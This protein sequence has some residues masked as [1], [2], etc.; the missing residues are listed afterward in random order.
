M[1]LR[2]IILSGIIFLSGNN[3]VSQVLPKD[4]D[5]L[6]YRL[7]GFQVPENKNATAYQLEVYEFLAQDDGNVEKLVLKKTY[8]RNRII[9]TVPQFGKSYKWQV[10]YLKNSQVIGSSGFHYFS[11]GYSETVDTSKYR[12]KVLENKVKDPDIY[13]VL[14]FISVIY[15]LDGN[16]LWYLPNIPVVADKNIQ[17][18]DLKPTADGTFTAVSGQGAHEFDYN[19]KILWTAAN[20]GTVSGAQNESYHHEFTKLSNGHFMVCG[21]EPLLKKVPGFVDTAMLNTARV[22]WH[23]DEECYYVNLK[24]ETLIEYDSNGRVV[25]YWK[26]S[27]HCSDKDFFRQGANKMTKI[28]TDMH[29]NAFEFDEKEKVI[30]ISFKNTNQ[31]VKIEYPS[32]KIIE[33]YGINSDKKQDNPDTLFYGQ[34]CIRK[35]KDGRLYLFNNNSRVLN[36]NRDEDHGENTS[37]SYITML[38]ENPE[39]RSGIEK[40]WEFPC[41]IDTF[42][43]WAGGAGG[44][45]TMLDNGDILASMGAASRVFIVTPDK[46]VLWNGIPQVSDPGNNWHLLGQYRTS[47]ITK[48]DLNKFIYK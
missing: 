31:I 17:M 26:S 3:A 27:E 38:K 42:A 4:N 47:Y 37:I 21:Q 10:K 16:P 46:K 36:M 9:E 22:E 11:T 48:K 34:H 14:D 12:L 29:M 43:M 35:T 23:D 1:L 45:V 7:V 30:Y 15:D 33:S 32:G 41:N 40:I 25:W 18:R 5:T 24:A 28:N 6:N 8:E 44:S 39:K 2:L 19:G 13:L 20:D